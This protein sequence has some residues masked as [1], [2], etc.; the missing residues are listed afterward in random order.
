V[1]RQARRAHTPARCSCSL[2]LFI[3]LQRKAPTHARVHRWREPQSCPHPEGHAV[4]RANQ[5]SM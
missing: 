5:V 4:D 1:K 2:V 3:Y